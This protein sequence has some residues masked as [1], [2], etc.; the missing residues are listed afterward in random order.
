MYIANSS[1]KKFL[2]FSQIN[3]QS[4]NLSSEVAGAIGFCYTKVEN[5]VYQFLS[6]LLF[7]SAYYKNF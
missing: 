5:D 4:Q 6:E 2:K 1:Q 7:N 3:H